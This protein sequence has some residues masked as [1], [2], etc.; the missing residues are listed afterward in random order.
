MIVATVFAGLVAG[1]MLTSG[2]GMIRSAFVRSGR[3]AWMFLAISA[4]AW[5]AIVFSTLIPY[6]VEV[7]TD[8]PVSV[9]AFSLSGGVAALLTALFIRKH[10]AWFIYPVEVKA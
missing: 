8:G 10:W 5:F 3:K 6:I 7:F 4:G 1:L 2:V 9:I